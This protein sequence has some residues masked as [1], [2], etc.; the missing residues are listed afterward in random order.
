MKYLVLGC[1][2]FG[3]LYV[4]DYNKVKSFS[5][6]LNVFF[7]LGITSL[8]YSTVSLLLITTKSFMVPF[9]LSLLFYFLALISAIFLFYALFG[10]LPFKSTYVDGN[11]TSVIDTG[12]YALC[13]HPGVWG[14]FLMYLFLFLASGKWILLY[15]CIVW[16]LMDILHVWVQDQFFFPKTLVGYQ[17]YQKNTPFLILNA[18]SIKNF[19]SNLESGSS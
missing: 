6:V 13:R 2:G 11:S 4:F 12:I 9:Y 7:P 19:K 3:F 17:E 10:A 8:A 14:L 15:S 1:L 18:K 5:K 16:T